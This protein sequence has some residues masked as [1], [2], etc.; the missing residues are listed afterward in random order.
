ML[1]V[2]DDRLLGQ[3]TTRGLMQ[4]G[5]AVDWLTEGVRV[6][7]A[8]GSFD[9]SCV[10]LDLGLPDI[11]GELCL[12]TIRRAKQKMPVIVLT[13]RGEKA[14]RISTLDIGA[15]DYLI[16]PFDVDELAARIRAV[17]RRA[18]AGRTNQNLE[19]SHGMLRLHPATQSVTNGDSPVVVTSK[20]FWL[21]EALIRNKD[22]IVTRQMLIEALYGWADDLTSNAIEVYVHQLRRKLGGHLIQ[23]VRGVGY[24]LS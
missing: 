15:D 19:L 5:Y 1:L 12:Q 11:P 7:A 22:R 16:K 20:E 4:M 18:G 21:L 2:E 24:R 14:T 13:A 10:L 8:V 23:T 17:V 9:Y 3:A 6:E